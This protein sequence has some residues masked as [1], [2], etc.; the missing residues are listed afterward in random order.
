MANLNKKM[1][2]EGTAIRIG[3]V[4]FSYPRLFEPNDKGKY[5]CCLLIE[6]SNTEALKLIEEG[7]TVAAKKGA[8]K[9]WSGKVPPTLKKPLHDGDAERPDDPAYANCMFIN[10][11]NKYPPQVGVWDEF[12]LAKIT[13]ERD[14]YAGC[15]GAVTLEFYPY[16]VDGSRGVAASM[17]NVIKL[18]DGDPLAGKAESLDASFADLGD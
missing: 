8:A 12:G 1:N 11:S 7:T 5:T 3:E 17:G 16:N 6:K 18:R 9:F 13:D 10:C 14:L 15:Y 4:R 2:N